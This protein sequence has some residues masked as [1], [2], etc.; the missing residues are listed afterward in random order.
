[1]FQTLRLKF[2]IPNKSKYLRDSIQLN[3]LQEKYFP[4]STLSNLLL[5]IK[6]AVEPFRE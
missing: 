2:Y 3:V 4:H 5:Q 6:Q 1:M